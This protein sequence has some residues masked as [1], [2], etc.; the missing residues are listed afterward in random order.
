[1]ETY[2]LRKRNRISRK[3]RRDYPSISRQEINVIEYLRTGLTHK[4]VACRLHIETSTVSKH[5]QNVSKRFKINKE[6]ALIDRYLH[7]NMAL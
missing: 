2:K 7:K 1:M 6:T 3:S 4:E 5:V